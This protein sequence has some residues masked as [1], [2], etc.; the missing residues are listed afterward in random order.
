MLNDFE[1][2]IEGFP[3]KKRRINRIYSTDY[4]SRS[5][6][7]CFFELKTKKVRTV[8]TGSWRETQKLNLNMR[9]RKFVD[10][11]CECEREKD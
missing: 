11:S 2:L 1:A 4:Q 9:A 5:G 10:E 7:Q 3:D 6:N 8:I